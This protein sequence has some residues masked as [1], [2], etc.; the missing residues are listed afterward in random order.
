M[1]ELKTGEG[2]L[3]KA[4]FPPYSEYQ[5]IPWDREAVRNALLRLRPV[6][7]KFIPEIPDSSEKII[8]NNP[9]YFIKELLTGT[10]VIGEESAKFGVSKVIMDYHGGFQKF[11][12]PGDEEIKLFVVNS[13]ILALL[14][15]QE[16]SKRFPK[17]KYVPSPQALSDFNAFAFL[18][19][20]E[21][22]I[23]DGDYS[24]V[25]SSIS[26]LDTSRVLE[27]ALSFLKIE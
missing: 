4:S 17:V 15:L 16:L 2:R 26:G 1:L 24:Y 18:Q 10:K 13:Y 9:H 21:Q 7:V 8:K 23:Q 22:K 14:L 3:T 20:I 27:K 5:V 25:I 19:E 6:E 12:P 11:Y